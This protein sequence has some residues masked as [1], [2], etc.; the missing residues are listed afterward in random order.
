MR[1]PRN[2]CPH[3]QSLAKTAPSPDPLAASMGTAACCL[4]RYDVERAGVDVASANLLKLWPCLHACAQSPLQTAGPRWLSDRSRSSHEH[5][6]SVHELLR[7]LIE[8]L[9]GDVAR[10]AAVSIP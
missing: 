6:N 8:T 2:R 9:A 4:L 5:R 7:W 1:W 3:V 10:P